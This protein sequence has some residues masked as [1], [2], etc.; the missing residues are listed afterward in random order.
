M[1]ANAAKRA[2]KA[3]EEDK[4]RNAKLYKELFGQENL[5]ETEENNMINNKTFKPMQLPKKKGRLNASKIKKNNE[6]VAAAPVVEEISFKHSIMIDATEFTKKPTI[7]QEKS[8]NMNKDNL[9]IKELSEAIKKGQCFHPYLLNENKEFIASSLVAIEVNNEALKQKKYGKITVSD[10]LEDALKSDVKPVLVYKALHTTTRLDRFVAVYQLDQV[11]DKLEIYI[12]EAFKILKPYKYANFIAP[13]DMVFGAKEVIYLNPNN[14][15][16]TAFDKLSVEQEEWAKQECAILDAEEEEAIRREIAYYESGQDQKDIEAE[17]EAEAEMARKEWEKFEEWWDNASSS[18]QKLEIEYNKKR[19]IW[20]EAR[21]AER[22]VKAANKAALLEEAATAQEEVVTHKV[23]LDTKAYS[24]KPTSL[25]AGSIQKRLPECEANVTVE[26][27]ANKLVSGHTFKPVFMTGRTQDT[28]VS[29]SLV[30]IDI[31]NKGMELEAYG[32]VSTEDFMNKVADNKYKPCIIYTTFSSSDEC[33]KYR[34]I[35]QLDR[36]VTN[37]NELRAIAAEIKTEYPYADAKVSPVHPIYG[38]K[39]LVLL[40]PNTVVATPNVE[41]IEEIK[42]AQPSKSTEIKNVVVEKKNINEETL[43]SN[44][45]VLK[46]EFAG[47][48]IDIADSFNWINKNVPMTI[49]LGYDLDTRFRC[50][51]PNH[52]DNNPSARISEAADGQQNYICSC[53]NSYKSLIDIIAE[54]FDI[55]KVIAQNIIADAI[56]VKIG[57]EYQRNMRLLV[58]DIMANTN[59]VIE[60]DSI[61]YKYMTRSNLHGLY[62]LIQQFASAHITEAPLG[63]DNQITFFMSQSQIKE[64]MVQYQM[65]GADRIGYKLNALKELGLIRALPDEEINSEALAKAKAIQSKMTLDNPISAKYMK[66]VEYY[67][68]CL[69]TPDE[70]KRAEDILKKQ[71]ELG[72]KRTNINS[73]R[74]ALAHGTE[75][76]SSINVQMNVEAK[77]NSPKVQKELDKVVAAAQKLIAEQKYFT[78]EQL[79]KAYDPNRK[80]RKDAAVKVINDALPLIMQQ[81]ELKKD[82]VKSS[83]KTI[84]SIPTDIKTNTNIY[85]LP[86]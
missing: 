86:M 55:N 76:A 49:A 15:V 57:S 70:I 75:F 48:T 19:K 65:K 42:A 72:V 68:L 18:H 52:A 12:D 63:A 40:N 58:A 59:K 35:F 53:T 8:I 2:A 44:L 51:L 61:I 34:A 47:T 60:K 46:D 10:Y 39:E 38:G 31:D 4:A 50:I 71:K 81:F 64:K 3:I 77:L 6:S 29:A 73:T 67:E 36:V 62:N 30:V 17:K 26:E 56:G 13:A 21:E 23:L 27:L 9:T 14:I 33:N 43:T 25:V 79:R 37:L 16:T 7:A 80:K 32:Y 66:R 74:R 54:T 69:I 41:F 82:R 28:F 1:K 78:E 5:L 24:M 83:T 11:I 85:I 84:Y 45:S 22:E 20:R